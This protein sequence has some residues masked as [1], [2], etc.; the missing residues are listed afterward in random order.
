MTKQ[1]D[2]ELL[3]HIG[4]RLFQAYQTW[5]ALFAERMVARG[6]PWVAEARGALMQHIGPGGVSQNLLVEKTGL[7]KQ[8]VQQHLDGLVKDGVI[9]R[10]TDPKD[11]RKKQVHLT[12]RG[13]DS[14]RI[15]NEVKNDIERRFRVLLG[16]QPFD[17]V[18]DAL[19]RIGAD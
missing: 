2:I 1:D 4:W 17:Q 6:C 15:A 18:K 13:V 16:D 11:A 9:E 7:T 12:E 8:A 14:Q 19:T 10:R 3:D 5:K